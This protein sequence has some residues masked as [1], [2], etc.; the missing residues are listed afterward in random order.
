MGGIFWL[1]YGETDGRQGGPLLALE[2]WGTAL[3]TGSPEL[4]SIRQCSPEDAGSV[5][6]AKAP[7]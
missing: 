6:V 2:E 1:V 4:S 5:I 3:E 7:E